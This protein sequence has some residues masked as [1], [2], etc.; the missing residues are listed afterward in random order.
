MWDNVFILEYFRV[1]KTSLL[2]DTK[3]DCFIV[4][5]CINSIYS[6][7]FIAHMCFNEPQCFVYIACGKNFIFRY[8]FTGI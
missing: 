5:S 3:S 7:I 8:N 2:K 6:N 4:K 1:D